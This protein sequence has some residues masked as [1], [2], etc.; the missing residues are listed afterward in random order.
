MPRN[1]VPKKR[2]YTKEQLAE[3]VDLI[4]RNLISIRKA[5]ERYKIDKS[6]LSRHV[7]GLSTGKQGRRT[8]LSVS[9]EQD[10]TEKL[11]IMAKWG[12]ALTK[13]DVKMSVQA[14]V[15][16]NNLETP[17]RDSLPG[18]E[19]F[20]SFCKR[21]R[22]S[23][24]KMEQ[25]EK[26]RRNATSNPFLI[27]GFFDILEETMSNLMLHDKPQNIWNLDETYFSLD[28]ARVKGVSAVGQK[29]H[30]NIE[31]S[32]KENMTVMACISASGACR[33]PLVIYQGKN[34][35]STWKGTNESVKVDYAV[36][37]KGWMT[38]EI[39]NSWFEKFCKDVK[40]RPL[41]II[42]DGHVSHLDKATIDLA[43]QQN[44]T[45]LKLPAH[46]TDLLQPLDKCCFGPLKLKWNKRLIEWQRMNQRRLTKSEFA[47]LLLEIWDEGLPVENIISSF[48]HT[49]R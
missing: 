33:P 43:L 36:S 46:T 13:E 34:L 25:L 39:F 42:L 48:K 24:K 17:F 41:L 44:I 31:G 8:C 28:P 4:K 5:A 14:Y 32:G 47:N 45:L 22:L 16:Q 37:E 10:L 9:E 23:Q 20:R 7:R 15:L 38:T 29:V 26:C 30:R 2:S 11:T 21:N 3:V 35:W 1:Y 18:D 6:T 19:W 40:E 12:F 27:F 49:G